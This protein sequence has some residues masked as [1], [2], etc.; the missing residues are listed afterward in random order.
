[1]SNEDQQTLEIEAPLAVCGHCRFATALTGTFS[2]E[3]GLLV[4]RGTPDPQPGRGPDLSSCC[5]SDPVIEFWHITA[6]GENLSAGQVA[7]LQ[8]TAAGARLQEFQE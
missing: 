8:A 7:A 2:V 5:E 6:D 4:W 1:V 3:D